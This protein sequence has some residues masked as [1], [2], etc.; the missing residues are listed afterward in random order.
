MKQLL[1]VTAII[2]GG[3]GLALVIG[4]S[5]LASILLGVS[6]TDPVAALFCRLAGASLISISIACWLSRR[7]QSP[8]LVKAMLVYNIFSIVILVYS[9]LGEG[10]SGPGLWPA[11]LLHFGFLIW[12]GACLRG[13]SANHLK[14][15]RNREGRLHV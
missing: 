10:I 2:E 15:Y 4:P 7:S 14:E 1:T 11:I 5:A 12:C 3:T 9:D 8:D 13:L 6:L